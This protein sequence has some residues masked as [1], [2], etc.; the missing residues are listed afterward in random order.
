[1]NRFDVFPG[2]KSAFFSMALAITNLGN[3]FE[4]WTVTTEQQGAINA[5]IGACIVI[6]MG[7][8]IDR[9]NR[10]GSQSLQG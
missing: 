9:K 6:S 10:H 7:L 8:K 3:L 4:L 1:M 5:V 2:W